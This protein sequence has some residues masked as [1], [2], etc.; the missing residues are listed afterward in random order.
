[1]N[2]L[3]DLYII[4]A[5]DDVDDG[6]IIL[7]SFSKHASI[8]KV[9]WVKNG[10]ELLD[11]LKNK[12]TEL[13]D[14]ILTDINMPI[15]NGIEALTEIIKDANLAH[16]PVFVYSSTLNPDYEAKCKQLGAVEYLIK[17]FSFFAFDEIPFKIIEI[18]EQNLAKKYL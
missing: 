11:L 10:K 3:K 8:T 16:I 9:D 2:S 1:M 13:P 5:E 12:P 7:R 14:F 17:P 18:L 6:E 4:I 15:I